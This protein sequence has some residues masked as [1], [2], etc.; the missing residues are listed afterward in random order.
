MWMGRIFLVSC[1]MGNYCDFL[2]EIIFNGSLFSCPHLVTVFEYEVIFLSPL[3][4]CCPIGSAG[5]RNTEK[6]VD[7]SWE[8][9]QNRRITWNYS[10]EHRCCTQTLS[11]TSVS[12]FKTWFWL[13]SHW[14]IA[15]GAGTLAINRMVQITVWVAKTPAIGNRVR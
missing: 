13:L 15:D 1:I 2:D 7:K 8:D 9:L 11:R 3:R 6:F 12:S 5:W 4:C 10:S 14:S